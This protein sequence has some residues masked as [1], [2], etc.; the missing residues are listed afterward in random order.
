M[1]T[2]IYCIIQSFVNFVNTE[3]SSLEHM[4][5][6]RLYQLCY[7]LSY[8]SHIP[9]PRTLDRAMIKLQNKHSGRPERAALL[10]EVKTCTTRKATPF[11]TRL[12]GNAPLP[13]GCG[14]IIT[15]AA[16]A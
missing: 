13:S 12:H 10:R 15:C 1:N 8:D 7:T 11:T 14:W 5:D 6:D 2:R 4:L 9:Y 16:I 3:F